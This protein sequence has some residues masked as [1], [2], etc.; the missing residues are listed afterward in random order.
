MRRLSLATTLILSI[1]SPIFVTAC[2]DEPSST[3]KEMVSRD[4]PVLQGDEIALEMYKSPTCQCCSKWTH[5]VEAFDFDVT[6]HH[7]DDLSE[8]KKKF[9][10]PDRYHA[11]HTSVTSDGFVFEGHI[12]A[13]F[14]RQYLMEKPPGT[15]GLT[16]PGMPLGSPGMNVGGR[17]SP[18]TI[19]LIHTDGSVSN[20]AE[21]KTY[22]D[23]YDID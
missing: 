22:E 1:I 15:L 2:S 5:H 19:F 17:F 10:V 9:G 18:Y 8:V 16:V 12:P 4:T 20:Y 23:Q 3:S 7:P 14:I 6:A 13:K 11:C 21:I